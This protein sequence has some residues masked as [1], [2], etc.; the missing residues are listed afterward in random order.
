MSPPRT[1]TTIFLTNTINNNNHNNFTP[2]I[3]NYKSS[4]KGNSKPKIVKSPSLL[5]KTL[6]TNFFLLYYVYIVNIK[7]KSPKEILGENNEESQKTS[8]LYHGSLNLFF[9]DSCNSIPQHFFAVIPYINLIT[10]IITN[11][12]KKADSHKP[13][14]KNPKCT[15][16]P[17]TLFMIVNFL[18]NTTKNNNHNNLTSSGINKKT[19]INKNN[20]ITAGIIDNKTN[21]KTRTTS[22]DAKATADESTAGNLSLEYPQ[23]VNAKVGVTATQKHFVDVLVDH[24]VG[25]ETSFFF[26]KSDF[27]D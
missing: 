6:S 19:S 21:S 25:H 27:K 14:Y 12:S 16:S 5:I 1:I 22:P 24:L 7:Q 26:K 18:T 10:I 15:V 23:H 8:Q 11:S 9:S 3:N 13:P 4:L 17:R 20:K 2:G